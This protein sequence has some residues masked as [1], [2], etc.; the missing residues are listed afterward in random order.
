ME[1]ES[2]NIGDILPQFIIV[3]KQVQ[4]VYVPEHVKGYQQEILQILVK[5]SKKYSVDPI[6]TIGFFLCPKYR[7]VATSKKY[8]LEDITKYILIQASKWGMDNESLKR[9]GKKI[10]FLIY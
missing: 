9:L 4:A 2:S 7:L 3:I 6:Y 10:F 5:Y 1:N 8:S